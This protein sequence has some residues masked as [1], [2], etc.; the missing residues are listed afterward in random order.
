MGASGAERD[1]LST[2]LVGRVE[3]RKL[4]LRIFDRRHGLLFSWRAFLLRLASMEQRLREP[5]CRGSQHRASEWIFWPESN[6]RAALYAGVQPIDF[7]DHSNH[8]G[9]LRFGRAF[10][11][12]YW[13]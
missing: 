8:D 10:P 12:W 1:L 7:R 11:D 2:G 13:I 9:W 6:P 3:L 4:V 5:K